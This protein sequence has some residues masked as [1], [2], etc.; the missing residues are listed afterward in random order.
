[1]DRAGYWTCGNPTITVSEM[2]TDEK[3][4]AETRLGSAL[5]LGVVSKFMGDRLGGGGRSDE[6]VARGP[7]EGGQVAG[8]GVGLG[9]DPERILHSDPLHSHP[10]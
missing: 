5:A 1:M 2:Q 7:P 10:L 4:E 9:V 6:A 3:G 8:V